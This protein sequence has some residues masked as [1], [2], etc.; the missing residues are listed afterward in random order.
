MG[1]KLLNF[2]APID[3]IGTNVSCFEGFHHFTA[4]SLLAHGKKSFSADGVITGFD[5]YVRLASQPSAVPGGS[6]D[7]EK[8]C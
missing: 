6:A 8:N 5:H 2:S 4:T 7:S 3:F 1:I